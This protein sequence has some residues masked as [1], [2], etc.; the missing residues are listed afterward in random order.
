[1]KSSIRKV[2]IVGGG[3][4]G[5]STAFALYE[6]AQQR[7][8]P[9]ECTVIEATCHWGGKILTHH[10][11]D[12]II[13]GGPDS[14]LSSKPWALELCKKLGIES[15]LL[16]TNE[17]QSKT[18]TYS[19]GKLREFPQGLIAFV[20]TKVGPLFKSGLLS[21]SGIFRMAGD[22]WLPRRKDPNQDESL[23]Q[24]F[25]RRFGK[26]AFARLI[27]PLVA[28]IYAGDAKELSVDATFPRF[29]ELE[30]QHRSLIKSMVAQRKKGGGPSQSNAPRRTLFTTLEG[31]LGDLV[32]TLRTFLQK[33]G[34][35]FLENTKVVECSPINSSSENMA[36][37]ITT[38][39]GSALQSDGLVLATPA[40]ESSRLMATWE[41]E[42]S[43]LLGQIPYASTATLSLAY[44]REQVESFI[45]GFG[46]V[47]P[48]IEGKHLIAAT[49][50]SVKWQKRAAPD[51]CLI[52]CYLGGRGREEI[53][54]KT[55]QELMIAVRQDL[56]TMVGIRSQPHYG[57]V[58][59]W[60]KGM[61]QY[62]VGHLQRVSHIRQEI[63]KYR[64]FEVTGA[65][66]EGIGIPDCIREGSRTA[67]QLAKDLWPKSHG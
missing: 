21:W 45:N 8:V 6:E 61:P 58:H 53:L 36:Y 52:R 28:G 32:E 60:H 3:I 31:G 16:N 55:D 29:V 42:A 63:E 67:S 66:F 48:R 26:E 47:V 9:L 51:H 38:D 54:E 5:L 50:T 14:F 46:F 64:G 37:R 17:S 41:P 62:L 7:D 18:F 33:Q 35:T 57:E 30:R 25:G 15:Q 49:W 4:S 43:Q 24:F 39:Q 2:V 12:L 11:D 65:A 23:S 27:E 40:Y 59:R 56:E 13:E 1:M 22:L 44:P 34:V 20:P 10:V 19:H